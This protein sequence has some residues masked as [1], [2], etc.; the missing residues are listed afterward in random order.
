[1]PEETEEQGWLSVEEAA[2]YLGVS[3]RAIHKYVQQGRL[4]A[5]KAPIGGRTLFKREDLD[6]FRKIR[7]ISRDKKAS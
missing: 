2:E 1:M 4:A 6:A 7:P 3:R 5:F